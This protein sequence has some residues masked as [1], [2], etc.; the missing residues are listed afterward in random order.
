MKVLLT[1]ASG[2]LGC[3]L[4]PRLAAAGFVIAAPTPEELDLTRLEA[5]DAFWQR[6]RPQLVINAAA[7][8]AVD[9]AE[10]EAGAAFAVNAEAPARLARLC[11]DTGA[12]LIHVSTDYVF[13]GTKSAPYHEDDPVNPLGVYGRSKA[14]G[15]EAVRALCPRHLVV[16]TSWLFSAHGVNFVKTLLRLAA[17]RPELRIVDDQHGCPTSAADLAQAIAAI[18]KRLRQEAHAIFPWGLY[19]YCG[20][21]V[22]TWYGFA[23]KIVDLLQERGFAR[24]V[25][26]VP[27]P[28]AAYPTPARRPAYS[29]L[30]CRRIEAVF[31]VRR[32]PWEESLIAVVERLLED[33]R[34]VGAGRPRG[35]ESP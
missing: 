2:Q 28:T 26:V 35:S 12:S 3:E 4:L 8:T 32:P 5:I 33:R 16:R 21:G 34:A 17:E 27:I 10:S 9:R 19:H 13:D 7:Y 15:E 18:V 22:T 20:E 1:G 6:N 30:D 29:V 24:G 25:Q 14:A 31:G 11:R 23:R